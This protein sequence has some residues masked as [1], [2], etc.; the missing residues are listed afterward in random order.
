VIAMMSANHVNPDLAAELFVLDGPP[1]YH[2]DTAG[3]SADTDSAPD[4]DAAAAVS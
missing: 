3:R 4:S 2:R 1:D